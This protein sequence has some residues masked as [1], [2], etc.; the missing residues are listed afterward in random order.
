MVSVPEPATKGTMTRI[1]LDGHAVACACVTKGSAASNSGAAARNNIEK[2]CF[3][4]T[5]LKVL[6]VEVQ[7]KQDGKQDG[8]RNGG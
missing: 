8:E 4:Q 2:G 5:S 7:G 1:G 3:M 6:R